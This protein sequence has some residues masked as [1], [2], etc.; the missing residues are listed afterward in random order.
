MMEQLADVYNSLFAQIAHPC[1]KTAPPCRGNTQ[2]YPK[3]L[4]QK[5]LKQ[6]NEII[7]VTLFIY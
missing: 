5:V 3:V 6:V 7:W 2:Q 1:D 4:F